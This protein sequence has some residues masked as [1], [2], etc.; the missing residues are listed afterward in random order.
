MPFES[1]A[2]I[3]YICFLT[4]RFWHWKAITPFLSALYPK[5]FEME[6]SHI[7]TQLHLVDVA[8]LT[9]DVL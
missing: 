5:E 2:K 4:S 9:V 3:P 6:S 8:Q 7:Q 1:F